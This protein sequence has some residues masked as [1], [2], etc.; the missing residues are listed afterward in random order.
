MPSCACPS[1]DVRGSSARRFSCLAALIFLLGT[2]PARAADTAH[3]KSADYLVD[4]F[5]DIAL[6][7][8]Y[9]TKRRQVRKWTTPI[10]YALIHQAG[11]AALH[12]RLIRTHFA[13]LAGLTGLG[14]APAARFDAANFLI[15]LTSESRL[16]DDF[17]RY[18]GWNSA[19]ERD[20][21]FRDAVCLGN[22]ATS[23]RT[24]RITRAVVI[25]PVDRARA[26][27]KLPACVVEELTQV[28]GLPN[29][30]DKVY[31]S[32]FN[33]H[34]TDVFLTGLDVL[35]LRMLYDPRVLHGMDE[36]ALRPVLRIIAA[37]I[38]RGGG[39]EQAEQAALAGGL[40]ALVP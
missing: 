22:F 34:S 4:A 33:D 38:A 19:A 20:K 14:I 2:L 27:G 21:F 1:P 7:S 28:L 40:S 13:H 39:F 6:G 24:G 36:A 9:A 30:S 15:V 12:E 10:S 3:W 11:D 32:I 25:I 23:R 8:E 17:Q 26:R 18:F 35:L 5:V 29:D 31:P 16:K 37:E